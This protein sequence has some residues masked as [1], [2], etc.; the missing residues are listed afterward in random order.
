MYRKY[1]NLNNYYPYS[2]YPVNMESNDERFFPFLAPFLLGGITGGIVASN[3]NNNNCCIPNC[4][5]P[6]IIYTY[7]PYNPYYYPYRK[8]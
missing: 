5:P 8:K 6:N 7:P 2:N 4:C 1:N 3:H